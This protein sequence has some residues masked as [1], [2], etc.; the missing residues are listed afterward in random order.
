M[1]KIDI[2][3]IIP[4]FNE[5]ENILELYNRIVK[6]LIKINIYDYEIIYI[7]DGSTDNSPE[8]LRKLNKEDNKVKTIIFTRNF[9]LQNALFAGL[10][11]STKEFACILD[12]DLQDPP[13]LIEIF[14]SKI[15]EG[16][17]IVY[18]IRKKREA[19]ILKKIS[20]KIFYNL[21]SILSEVKMPKDVGEF[22]LLKRKV[23]DTLLS[24]NESH[25]FIR[26]LRSWTGFKQTGIEYHRLTRNAGKIKFNFIKLFLLGLD[27][28]ISFS[29]IPLRIILIMSILLFF[30][31]I[32]Y[33]LFILTFK[34]LALLDVI[35]NDAVLLMPKGLTAT[36][37]ILGFLLVFIC[38]SLGLIGEYI[39]KI[40][41]EIKKRPKYIIK[42]I[43]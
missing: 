4:S 21:F 10:K 17:E 16:Y 35:S 37:I 13:E 32:I 39:G 42:E 34:I 41:F 30:F 43:I 5:S 28:I 8:I 38:L 29:F 12:G 7:D 11:Y 18:G 14:F 20:Y 40:Y 36:N 2:S 25:I 1:R 9:G 22:C 31:F 15:N 19:G 33:I 6:T 3:I 26:G 23:I 27:G 24:F